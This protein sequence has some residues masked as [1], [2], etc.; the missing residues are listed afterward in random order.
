MWVHRSRAIAWVVIGVVAFLVGW[1]EAI[2]LLWIASVYA[3]VESAW[4][5][6][7]AVDHR[8][9][10]CRLDRIERNQKAETGNG[11]SQA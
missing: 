2:W 1:H 5:T 7:E 8:D 11:K 3:N 6:G 9:I 10:T 4:T